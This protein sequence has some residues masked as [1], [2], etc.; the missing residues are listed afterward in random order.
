VAQAYDIPRKS[1]L[2]LSRV[3]IDDSVPTNSATYMVASAIREIKRD[4][5][6]LGLVSFADDF[7]KHT[8][9]IYRAGNW[10]YLGRGKSERVW[11]DPTTGDP[12]DP[13]TWTQAA[14]KQDNRTYR[15]EEMEARGLVTIGW[16]RKYRYGMYIGP[17]KGRRKPKLS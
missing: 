13:M 4:G 7:R 15:V 6:F 9:L 1:V 16:S 17:G 11:A 2:D 12:T 14:K 10:D 3:A 5:R 8:G